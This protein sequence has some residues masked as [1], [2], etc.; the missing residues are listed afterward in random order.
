MD[1]KKYDRTVNLTVRLRE[2]KDDEA[3]PDV[4]LYLIG[5]RG[6]AVEKLAEVKDDQV[7]VPVAL[8]EEDAVI[9]L[10]PDTDD[11]E[12]LDPSTLV[13]LRALDVIERW[14][15]KV[16]DIPA[17]RWRVWLPIFICISGKAQ[18]CG[19]LFPPILPLADVQVVAQPQRAIEL[20]DDLIAPFPPKC[21]PLCYGT[22][23]IYRRVCCCDPWI[24]VADLPK[25]IPEI[26]DDFPIPLPDPPGPFPGPDPVPLQRRLRKFRA[27]VEPAKRQMLDERVH[28]DLLALQQIEGQQA[29]YEYIEARPYLLPVLCAS[30]TC[31][32]TK[33]GQ[34]ELNPDGSFLFCFIPGLVSV[35][36]TVTYAYKV[37][38]LVGDLLVA[39]YNGLATHTWFSAGES[40]TLT[41]YS[42]F[43]RSCPQPEPPVEGHGLPFVMLQNIGETGT[44]QLHSPKQAS[45]T[46]INALSLP[47]NAGLL[48]QS[49]SNDCPLAGTL[50]LLLYI[51][52]NMKTTGAE[53]YRFSLVPADANGNP[54]GAPQVL[55]DQLAWLK[56]APGV[57]PPKPEAEVLGPKVVGATGGLYSIPYVDATHKWL[58]GQSHY[59]LDTTQFGDGRYLLILDLFDAAGNKIKPNGSTGDGTGANFHYI[60]WDT[61]SATEVVPYASLIHILHIDNLDCFTE[62]EDLRQNGVPSVVDCQFLV[63]PGTDQLSVGFRA[64]HE[65]GFMWHWNIHYW[66]GLFGTPQL[67]DSGTTN[68]P[69]TMATGAPAVSAAAT[70]ATML[71]DETQCTFSIRLRAYGKHTN[72]K[73]RLLTYDTE[74]QGSFALEI[75]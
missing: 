72:G 51:D 43:A 32:T 60:W 24:I 36:C 29:Q 28:R 38:Q 75:T 1:E 6:R 14:P 23:E 52:P 3:L 42:P 47:A 18:K 39:V 26:I 59:H 31:T 68:A 63:G 56:F 19:P 67:L 11:P 10:G 55:D 13:Q 25:R 4:A 20:I 33:I 7:P 64:Y 9:A 35:N 17:L 49:Y 37:K 22:V 65:N 62:I 57:W 66:R 54:A 27:E 41:T 21:E 2:Q 74:H 16:V 70:F 58:G 40:A 48:D 53:Y 34:V 69:P 46:G 61:L 12:S 5:A 45:A 50:D 73:G 30:V 8:G 44:H 71:G 15:E